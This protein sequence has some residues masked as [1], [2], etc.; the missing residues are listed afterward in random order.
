MPSVE[1][2]AIIISVKDYGE[3]DRLVTFLTP[4]RGRLTGI[5]KHA[6]RSK[7]RFANCL[8]PLSR[9][10]LFLSD[11][12]RGNLEF[13]EKGEAGR[14]F[15]ALRRDL[16][17]LG[18]A[19][20]LGELA[21]EMAS[22]P[23]ATSAIFAALETAFTLL[24]EGAPP[25]SLLPGFLLHLLKLG[26]YG[27]SLHC[28]QVCGQEP[29]PPILVSLSQGGILCG[30]CPRG[31]SGPQV[32]LNPGSW[33]LLRLAQDLPPEKLGRLRFPPGQRGQSLGLLRLFIRHHLGRELKAWSFWDKV[34]RP[35]KGERL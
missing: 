27:L 16:A 23:E 5:A 17:R 33:K 10:T 3:A 34:A 32:S 22:P 28:C 13:L 15:P 8:E 21:A 4:E 12:S 19:A 30:A 14:S 35:G 25:D 2:Q 9:V 1:T 29:Q 31:G 18:A 6:R 26:G 7:K 20:L 11:R 24:N